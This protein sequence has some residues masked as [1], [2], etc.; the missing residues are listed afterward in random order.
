M[1]NESIMQLTFDAL[2]PAMTL[3]PLNALPLHLTV[4]AALFGTSVSAET[5]NSTNWKD[6]RGWNIS[7]YEDQGCQLYNG[8]GKTNFWMGFYPIDDGFG[9]EILLENPNWRSIESG[10]EYSVTVKFGTRSP[11]SIEMEGQEWDDSFALRSLNS[12]GD[13]VIELAD[14]FKRSNK[15]IWSYEGTILQEFSLSGSSVAFDELI[16]CQ[17]SV[18]DAQKSDPFLGSSGGIG[19]VDPF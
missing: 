13:D 10:K 17:Q 19:N 12:I 11:W 15:M 16:K 18:M 7:Y 3:N 6:V 1:Q 2:E 5:I 8:T 14:E 9:W 4:F